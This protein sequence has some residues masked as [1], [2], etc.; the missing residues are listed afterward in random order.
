MQKGWFDISSDG[1][2][3]MNA[4]RPPYELVKELVQNIMDEDFSI[5][6]IDFWIDDDGFH[7][8]AEDDVNGGIVDYNLITTVF[9]TGKEDSHLK[10]GRKGRGLKEILSVCK[11]ATVETVGKTIYFNED[12]SRSELSNNRTYGTKIECIIVNEKWDENAVKDINEYLNKIII[13]KELYINSNL[14][15]SLKL[16]PIKIFNSYL[17]TQLIKDGIQIED[18][19][20]TDVELYPSKDKKNGWLYEMGIPV[21]LTDIPYDINIC[22]RI[23]MNDNR[24]QVKDDYLRMLKSYIINNII[25]ELKAEDIFGWASE[26]ISTYYIDKCVKEKIIKIV[27]GRSS[28]NDV[29]L[30]SPKKIYNDKAKQHG[31]SIININ[32]MSYQM[33]N[34]FEEYVCFSEN[35]IKA[36]EI[37]CEPVDVDASLE[38]KKLLFAHADLIQKS[39]GKNIIFK[40]VEKEPDIEGNKTF[41]FYNN[42]II[43]YN[44]LAVSKTFWK[45][46]YGQQALE[47]LLHEISHTISMEHDLLFIEA[48][49]YLGGKIASY[50][51]KRKN[52]VKE[53]SGS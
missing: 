23:P 32:N 2:K 45:N 1:W 18:Y 14:I 43:A 13:K 12:K 20:H 22:Q 50:L 27:S 10:R 51:A 36:I 38:E 31:K 52:I 9:L 19:K 34:I 30:K 44:R 11:T 21:M 33:R 53:E 25:D 39:I 29:V 46:P 42:N 40:V 7:V 6:T 4:G 41:G 35:Y 28:I 47:L 3:R 5:A 48:M 49:G 26:G 15:S 17:K 37:N 16:K 24:N 8:V